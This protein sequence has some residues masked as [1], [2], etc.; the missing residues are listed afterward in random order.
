VE[1][2]C[3]DL[4]FSGH[5]THGMILTLIILR[6]A[7][8]LKAIKALA[9]GT[10]LLLALALLAFRSHYTSDVVVAVY[11]TLMIWRLMPAEPARLD[12]D[13]LRIEEHGVGS[14][15]SGGGAVG[16]GH[17]AVVVSAAASSSAASV[18]SSFALA[19]HQQQQQQQQQQ[20]GNKKGAA[21]AAA[22]FADAQ[23][24]LD[25][26]GGADEGLLMEEGRGGAAGPPSARRKEA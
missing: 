25:G 17:A 20:Q 19:R 5:T 13:A 24:T 23:E 3:G 15:G 1:G 12:G 11:V 18:A 4:L 2:S 21:A 26:D 16:N 10:M 8:G 6:Y 22:V 9:I 7:P 14:S